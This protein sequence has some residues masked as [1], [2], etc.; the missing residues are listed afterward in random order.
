MTIIVIH[1]PPGTGKT[2]NARKF[3]ELYGLD[4]I[5][6]D[7]VSRHQPF[8]H[9]KALVLTTRTPDQVRHWRSVSLRGSLTADAIAFVPI[10]TALRRIGAA[11]P[12]PAPLP[13]ALPPKLLTLQ[14]HTALTYISCGA[15]TATC[16]IV[17]ASGLDKVAGQRAARAGRAMMKRLERWGLARGIRARSG[18][19]VF[20]WQIT[21]AGR[22][23]VQ[24]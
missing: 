14:E 6:D 8:P 3:A 1:G 13:D 4:T 22:K 16:H 5:V 12:V 18:G 17:R 10:V 21:D 2:T 23:A 15:T 9:K 19:N 11:L 7:G 24:P 20:W